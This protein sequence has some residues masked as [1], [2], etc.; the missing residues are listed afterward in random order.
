[1]S[2]LQNKKVTFI[3][4]TVVNVVEMRFCYCQKLLKLVQV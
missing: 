2:Y 3:F 1:M 4:S